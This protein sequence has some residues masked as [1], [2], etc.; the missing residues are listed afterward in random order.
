MNNNTGLDAI[1]KKAG[2]SQSR[3]TNEKITD[4]ARGGFEK[5]SGYVVAS[6]PSFPGS[7]D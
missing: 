7:L 2:M 4:G 1:E 6:L 3:E 5:M